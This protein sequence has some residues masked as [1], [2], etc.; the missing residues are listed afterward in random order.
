MSAD[1]I[2]YCLEHLTDYRQFERLC[3]DVMAGSGHSNIEP[4]GGSVD[5]G[6]DALHRSADGLTIFAY[7]VRSDW[8]RKLEQDCTRIQEEQ[9]SPRHIVFVCISSIT[10]HEKDDAQAFVQTRFGWT[11]EIYELERLRILLASPL[12]HLVAQHP[13][14]FCPPWFPQR[15]GLSVS[16]SADTIVIDHLPEDHALATWLDRKLTLSG[17]QTWCF[18]IAPLAGDDANESVRVLIDRRAVQ[19]VP[20]LSRDS[21]A[22][23]DFMDRCG[24]AGARDGLVL[25]CWAEQLFD[26]LGTSRL[27][28]VEPA[29]FYESWSVGIQDV[30]KSLQSRGIAP[31]YQADQGRSIALRAYVPEPVTKAEPERI[32]ANVFRVSLPK[33]ILVYELEEVLNEEAINTLRR[34]WP[35][36]LVNPQTVLAFHEPPDSVPR[37]RGKRPREYAWADYEESEGKPTINV[38][39][40]LVRRSLD[41][42]CA[43]AGLAWCDD[44]HVFYFSLD[45]GHNRNVSFTHVDGRHTHVAVTGDRQLG[46]GERA[47]HFRYQLAP[48]F[49]VGR[50]EA[51]DWWVTMRLYIRVTDLDGTPY[52]LKEI[53]RRR[54]AV[55]KSWWNKEWLARLLGVMQALKGAS[56]HIEVGGGRRAVTVSS[57]PLQWE[58]PIA[59]D[60]EAMTRFEGFQKEMAEARDTD[61]DDDEDEEVSASGPGEGLREESSSD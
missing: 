30:L 57:V 48:Q 7:T 54:K 3:S 45:Q 16:T 36:V 40:E 41:V 51:G 8:R 42:A 43:R 24:A 11:L 12:R 44:R 61:E 59:I 17:F 13:A 4:I 22:D 29:R 34:T 21:L 27:G 9:H 50:D 1:P 39:K 56:E 6:R 53:T 19:Y 52:Q 26:L 37:A 5:R 14:I 31:R 35:F 18:G 46:W 58:C 28:R 25:P 33:P 49:R 32:F 47:S 20:V 2:I 10:G 23:R 55:T 60:V 38:V 15:G